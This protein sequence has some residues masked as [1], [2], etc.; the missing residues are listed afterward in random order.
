MKKKT[1]L[2]GGGAKATLVLEL[3]NLKDIII[4]DPYIKKLDIKKKIPFYNRYS[5]LKNI[6]KMCSTFFVCIGNNNGED[7]STIAEKLISKKMKPLSL[8]HKKSIIH[9]SVKIGKMVMIMPGVVINPNVK[10]NNFC[11]INTS[12]VIEHN[13]VLK[14]GVEIM[15]SASLAGNCLVKKNATV[16]TNATIFP[17]I[18]LNENSYVGSGSVVRHNVKKSEIIVG[19]PAKFLKKN[20]RNKNKLKVTLSNLSSL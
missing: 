2:W 7:R 14:N 18:T 19:N 15:G 4:F 9:S 11:V 16:G 3:F 6:I 5:D 10:I 1:L 17:S 13:C 12:A 20:I 8:I